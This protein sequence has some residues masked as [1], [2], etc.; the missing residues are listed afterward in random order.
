MSGLRA[1]NYDISKIAEK[2][3]YYQKFKQKPSRTQF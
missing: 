3:I 1:E 2:C